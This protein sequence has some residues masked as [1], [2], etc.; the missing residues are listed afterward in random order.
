[1]TGRALCETPESR[2]VLGLVPDAGVL[3]AAPQRQRTN[4]CESAESWANPPNCGHALHF[5]T[6]ER[7]FNSGHHTP[8]TGASELV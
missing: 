7:S 5:R 8:M 1:M 6:D 3:S 4:V 2:L